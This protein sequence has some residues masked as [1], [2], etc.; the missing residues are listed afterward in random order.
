ME[1][2]DLQL[3]EFDLG[4]IGFSDEELRELLEETR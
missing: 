2:K 3:E 4:V 1:L